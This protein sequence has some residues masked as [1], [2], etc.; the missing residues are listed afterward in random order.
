VRV[1]KSVWRTRAAR[2][3]CQLCDDETTYT[4]DVGRLWILSQVV[5]SKLALVR[6]RFGVFTGVTP[7]LFRTS[8]S[9]STRSWYRS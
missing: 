4:I 6:G 9:R 1:G 7:C 5:G 2:T 3:M 8:P